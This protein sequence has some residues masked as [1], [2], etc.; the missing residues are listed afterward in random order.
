MIKGLFKLVFLN[1]VDASQAGAGNLEIIV[2]VNG[3]HVPNY[4]QSE[5][6]AK[7]KVSFKPQEPL[8]HTLSVRFNG[9][10][11]PGSPFTCRVTDANQILVSGTGVKMSPLNK[12]A[13]LLIDSRGAEMSD[14]KVSVISTSGQDI[15]VNLEVIDG[16]KFKADFLPFEVGECGHF[17]SAF[18]TNSFIK[19]PN[20]S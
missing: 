13:S 14:C 7:F 20:S 3:R 16:G 9:E 4:V 6:N 15:P 11:V 12:P 17:C 18:I 1:S 5:G 19:L 2:S 8:P 10:A